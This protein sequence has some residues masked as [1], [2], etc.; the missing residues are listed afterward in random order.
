MMSAE[1]GETVSHWF[2]MPREAVS[3]EIFQLKLFHVRGPFVK[4]N[5]DLCIKL[6]IFLIENLKIV[7]NYKNTGISKCLADELDRVKHVLVME[8]L[9]TVMLTL[10]DILTKEAWSSF[11]QS[12][13]L[14][15][16]DVY[17]KDFFD[18]IHSSAHST[19][20]KYTHKAYHPSLYTGIFSDIHAIYKDITKLE[21]PSD[22]LHK[23]NFIRLYGRYNTDYNSHSDIV[24]GLVLRCFFEMHEMNA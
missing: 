13:L 21:I 2:S 16:R 1:P 8:D 12:F 11:L 3:K 19:Y 15:L 4:K 9:E 18:I 5:K 24:R 23:M 7:A 14:F 17:C 20:K 6:T 10:M 22:M